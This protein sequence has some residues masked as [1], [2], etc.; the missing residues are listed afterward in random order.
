MAPKA[1]GR[2]ARMG[3]EF[4]LLELAPADDGL[5]RAASKDEERTPR[6]AFIEPRLPAAREHRIKQFPGTLA[7]AIRERKPGHID[8][9][10]IHLPSWRKPVV[11]L[12]AQFRGHPASVTKHAQRVNEIKR[13]RRKFCG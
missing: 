1:E 9:V 8:V 5:Q 4:E 11:E 12:V 6:P 13:A 3:F 10:E 7:R 2:F